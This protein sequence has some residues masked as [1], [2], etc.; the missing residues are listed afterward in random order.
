VGDGTSDRFAAAH[1]DVIFAKGRLASLCAAEG[2]P[3]RPWQRLVDVATWLDDALLGGDL[4]L[5]A[6]AFGAW[7]AGRAIGT[8]TAGGATYPRP[9][10]CGPE[11]W[12]DDR[13]SPPATLPADTGQAA[14]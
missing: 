12:G 2:W 3:S 4:P 13:S 8:S 1:A 7:L 10:I 11:V 5:T 6:G 9:F 14:S